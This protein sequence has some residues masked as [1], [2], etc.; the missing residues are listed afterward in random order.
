MQKIEE[1]MVEFQNW[2]EKELKTNVG[3]IPENNAGQARMKEAIAYSLLGGGKRIR[4]FMIEQS[5]EIFGFGRQEITPLL[6]AIEMVHAYSLI[7]DDLPAM[8]NSLERR[9]KP[10]VHIKFDDA[11]AL[12]TGNSLLGL[13]FDEILNNLKA[14]SEIKLNLLKNL[15][16]SAGFHG[17]MAGQMFDMIIAKS[18]DA[19]FEDVSTMNKMKTGD[20]FA[21]CMATGAILAGKANEIKTLQEIGYEFGYIFQVVDDILDFEE[22]TNGNNDVEISKNF[23][24][25]LGGI[26]EAKKHLILRNNDLK[27]KISGVQYNLPV[28]AQLVDFIFKRVC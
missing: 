27:H 6:V 8:D 11:T 10:S 19:K 26:E 2:L 18:T 3:K 21:F 12:L 20:L 28:M 7:H 16:F 24:V 5:C 4:A 9:G 25:K 1:I 23:I 14:S 13:A 22:D 15:S 17:M